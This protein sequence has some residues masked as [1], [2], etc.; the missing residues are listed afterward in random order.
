MLRAVDRAHLLLLSD[1]HRRTRHVPLPDLRVLRPL[2][3]VEQV[4]AEC[5]V[6]ICLQPRDDRRQQDLGVFQPV[7]QDARLVGWRAEAEGKAEM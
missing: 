3:A 2:E 4:R 1:L 6:E 7:G 5:A